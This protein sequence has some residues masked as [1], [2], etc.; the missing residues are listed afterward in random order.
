MFEAFS[1]RKQLQMLQR[2]VE[3]ALLLYG[4]EQAASFLLQY[5][6]N[7]VYRIVTRTGEVFVLRVSAINGHKVDVQYSEIQWLMALRQETDLPV[8]QPIFNTNGALVTTVDIHEAAGPRHCA[9]FSW[10]PGELPTPEISSQVFARMGAFTAHLHE[11]A[12]HFVP[13]AGFVRPHWDWQCVFGIGQRD[14][15]SSLSLE[16][17]VLLEAVSI[18]MQDE[19]RILGT[20]LDQWG[21]IHADLHR[22]NVLVTKDEQV[23]AIDFDDCGWGYYLFDI[24]SLLDSF[25]RRVIQDPQKYLA[26]REVYLMGYDQIRHLPDQLDAQLTACKALRDM[27]TLNFILESKNVSVQK[28][29]KVRIEQIM[30]HLKGYIEGK[31]YQ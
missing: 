15:H 3:Q 8:P 26:M 10:V 31:V 19:L 9:L 23:G 28:W 18:R 20:Q 30:L 24:A 16:Q 27:V 17:R 7:A 5:E 6:D 2:I 12:E 25:S 1:R 4:L 14:L 29:G 22:D 21:L 11:H 13:P